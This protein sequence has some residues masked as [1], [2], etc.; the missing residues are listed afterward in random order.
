MK[1]LKIFDWQKEKTLYRYIKS[2]DIFCYQI[3]EK[4]YGYGRIIAKNYWSA[5]VEI[6]DYFTQKPADFD[7]EKNNDYP[8]LFKCILDC[9]TLFQAKLESDWRII[10]Q[11]PNY[12][13]KNPKEITSISIID[14][15][16]HN[17]DFTY[18]EIIGEEK[19]LEM[20][21]NRLELDETLHSHYHILS[22]LIRYKP[23][24]FCCKNAP[25]VGFD[26]FIIKEY[27]NIHRQDLNL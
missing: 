18:S 21:K 24:L 8:V 3:S 23:N 6:F 26:S 17:A 9:V 22:L 15:M 11:D 4:L 25:F 27:K 10:A 13:N 2:G 19:A 14:G 16:A 1:K 7:F 20:V 12:I 5:T